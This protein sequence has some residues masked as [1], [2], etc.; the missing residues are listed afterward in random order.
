MFG[1]E[2]AEV[3]LGAVVVSLGIIGSWVAINVKQG[4]T[5]ERLTFV[6]NELKYMKDNERG[7]RIEIMHLSN[8]VERLD[9][10]VKEYKNV[11]QSLNST[12]S[13]LN[14]TL[15]RMDERMK[16]VENYISK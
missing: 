5:D 3:L 12:L 7:D 10:D 15:G 11:L 9:G 2:I 13:E 16:N 8:T 1:L 4:R 14:V 6:E